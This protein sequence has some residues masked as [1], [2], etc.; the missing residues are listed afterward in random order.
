MF[1]VL[2]SYKSLRQENA[3]ARKKEE[4]M[5]E[6][7]S[8]II[9]VYNVENQL[10]TCLDSVLG[11]TYQN[12]EIILINY[13]SIDNSDDICRSYAARDSRILYFKKNN[14][15]L[16]DARHIGIRQA[17]GAY[18]TYVDA[19]DWV[20]STYLEELYQALQVHKADIAVANY[21]V[22]KESED[23][24]YFYIK[25]EDYYEQVYSPAQI[26]D[27]LFEESNNINIAL[28]SATGK[29][30]KRSLFNDLLFPK[31]H[32]G[33]D[34]FFN[35][36]AY[37]MSER[38]VY[39]NK[40]LYVYRE[41]PEMPSA[42]WMQDWMMTLVYAMEERLAI[43][44]SHG[45]SLEKYM[46]TYR[47]MLETCLKNVEEL[48]LT[49]SEAYRSI[50]E[51]FQVLSLAPRRY[52]TKKHAIVLAANYAY[53]DQVLTTIKSIVF[54]H[55]NIRFYL[56]N[57]D[58]SQEWFR[59]L[60]RHLAAFGSEV[61]NCRVDSSHIKQYKTNSNY[62][63]YLRYFV[64]DFVSEE[65]ALYLD[66]DMVVTGSLED[67]FTLDLQGR[68]LAAVRDYAIQVQNRQM[69]FDADFMV[70]DMTYWK[71]YNMRNH[72][73]DM[74]SEWHDKVPFA[75]QSIL[76]M[77]F[78]NNWLA[79]SFDNN[80][81][82]TKSSLVG[83]HLPNGQDY[84]K[85]LHYD[86]HRKPWL[87]LACQAYREVWWFYAQMDWSEVAGNAS[88]LPL[89]EDML[90][91]K[92]RPFTCLVYTNISEIPHL[93]DLISA[94]PK[95]QFKI[96]SR[97]HVS[98]KLA[99]LITYPNVTVYSAIAGLNGLDLELVRTSDLLLDINPG[100]KVVEILDA[101]RFEN[102][103]ILGF[104]DLKSTKHNQQTYSR[105]RWKE[106]A[107]TIRQMRKKSL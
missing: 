80:Y 105:D 14:G 25:D 62:A 22:Y 24:F 85:V 101:F 32:A 26:I 57:D 97:Q 103:P 41:S 35:L 102:K 98:D 2:I 106:M 78:R 77:V 70:I 1:T 68:S 51:K 37:L 6:K 65:R 107:E 34:G 43:V 56:I 28:I 69:M 8:V 60:N 88:L 84:P 3:L 29:L 83:Y 81:A 92:G 19:E 61:I 17:K 21:S 44:A 36:K 4:K 96:A 45:F 104:E 27:G 55:R 42:T 31:E 74:T 76:N 99:Q 40:G 66:S 95:V 100:R 90:Y 18:V 16:S 7:I 54:H 64:T 11:Q 48:G 39:L 9:P 82:V 75:E 94:L 10:Q 63:S 47:Q 23:L 46:V 86:S 33:E 72:L 5:T 15:G 50:Q 52:E 38:T 79:L 53:V 73:I 89:S 67:L 13:G 91:P 58:F 12:I 49:D 87:P 20:E 93:T 59:G 71:Q 30:Y